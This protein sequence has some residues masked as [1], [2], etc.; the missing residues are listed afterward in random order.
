MI[1]KTA[2]AIVAALVASCATGV[3]APRAADARNGNG[4]F[5]LMA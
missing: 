2:L 4:H 5:K 1:N 3:L